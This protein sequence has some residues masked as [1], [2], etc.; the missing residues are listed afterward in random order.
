M[1]ATEVVARQKVSIHALL[2][3]CDPLPARSFTSGWGFNPRTPCGVR[4]HPGQATFGA[5][6]F[7]PRTPCGVRPAD[8]SVGAPTASGFNPRTPCGVRPKTLTDPPEIP[9]FN[10]RTP[11]GVRLGQCCVIITTRLVSIHALL[12]E[13]DSSAGGAGAEKKGFNPRTPC[14]VRPIPLFRKKKYVPFQSTHSL[15][16]AT[17]AG[18][19]VKN[20]D[21]VSIHALLVECDSVRRKPAPGPCCFNPR[22]PCGVRLHR[23]PFVAEFIRFQ[24]THSLW[25]ATVQADDADF[26]MTGFN[27]RTPCGVRPD[28]HHPS[29]SQGQ[30]SIHA[31]L[32]E[33]DLGCVLLPHGDNGFNP[34]T[35]CGV[36]LVDRTR[37]ESLLEMVSIHALLVECD[38]GS[39]LPPA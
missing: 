39:R 15:W 35:P 23:S 27:P 4:Q 18:E 16:S 32:V 34:R 6:G 22:T 3:E 30:V 28:P 26:R 10:P 1:T 11:C 17:V 13:C 14:G 29:A 33:C 8:V 36:R 31:L 2:V 7:N 19:A 9:G 25:S 12:V 37:A 24:S 21:E 5:K 20:Y 38:P